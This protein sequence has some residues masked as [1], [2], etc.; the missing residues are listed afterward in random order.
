[1][2]MI[3]FYEH[4]IKVYG[5]KENKHQLDHLILANAKAALER[6][7]LLSV[8]RIVVDAVT[9]SD[10]ATEEELQ[11]KVIALEIIKNGGN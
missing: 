1:M 10:D 7:K 11:A 8:A 5:A 4:T 2:E 9:T 3:R 6:E